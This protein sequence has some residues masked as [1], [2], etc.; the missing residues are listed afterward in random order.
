MNA[1]EAEDDDGSRVAVVGAEEE[2]DMAEGSDAAGV[3]DGTETAVVAAAAA[4]ATFPA[5]ASTALT[6]TGSRSTE[7]ERTLVG[8]MGRLG[9]EEEEA[10]MVIDSGRFS[11]TSW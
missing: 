3:I 5:F 4:A 7:Q 11:R 1:S 6:C 2:A 10:A 8:V 9:E